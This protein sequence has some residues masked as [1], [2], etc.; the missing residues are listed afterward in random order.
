M[1][2]FYQFIFILLCVCSL[3][4]SLTAQQSFFTDAMAI[5]NLLISRKAVSSSLKNSERLKQVQLS[6]EFFMV[7]SFRKK[8]R[9]EHSASVNVASAK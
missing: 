3:N 4:L 6:L 5:K 8:C 7:T 1:R 9:Q 2:Q